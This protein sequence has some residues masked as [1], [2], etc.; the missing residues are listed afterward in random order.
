MPFLERAAVDD[1]LAAQAMAHRPLD[2]AAEPQHAVHVIPV[3]DA[4]LVDLHQHV[5]QAGQPDVARVLVV[6]LARSR[7]RA[8]VQE[9]GR[10]AAHAAQGSLEV[11][12]PGLQRG[13]HRGGG[14][15]LGLVEMGDVHAGVGDLVQDHRKVAVDLRGRGAAVVIGVLDV[16]GADLEPALGELHGIL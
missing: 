3:L 8:V 13:Q 7:H 11:R 2:L 16:G 12:D 9:V 14:H 10:L 4:H 6:V 15:A 5:L 1:G